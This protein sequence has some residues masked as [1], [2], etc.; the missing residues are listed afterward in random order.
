MFRRSVGEGCLDQQDM[1]IGPRENR[2]LNDLRGL[3]RERFSSEPAALGEI[4]WQD[5]LLQIQDEPGLPGDW[6][7]PPDVGL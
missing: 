7:G 6:S 1:D 3:K 5:T 4:A 2:I